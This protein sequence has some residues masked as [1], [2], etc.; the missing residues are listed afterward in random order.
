MT[1][2]LLGTF[3]G[4]IMAVVIVSLLSIAEGGDGG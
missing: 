2:F 4:A 3:F 1:T